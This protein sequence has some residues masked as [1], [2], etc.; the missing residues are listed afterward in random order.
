MSLEKVAREIKLDDFPPN[1]VFW[2]ETRTEADR[3]KSCQVSLLHNWDR[4]SRLIPI[5]ATEFLV[6]NTRIVHRQ[7]QRERLSV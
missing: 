2:P 7:G 5:D 4:Y 6:C 3:N 1:S